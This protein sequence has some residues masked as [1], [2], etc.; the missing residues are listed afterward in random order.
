[1]SVAPIAE[2][3]VIWVMPD[4]ERRPGRIAIG[5]PSKMGDGEVRCEFLLDGLEPTDSVSGGSTFEALILAVRLLGNR[6]H[7][8]ASRGGSVEHAGFHYDSW[9]RDLFGSLVTEQPWPPEFTR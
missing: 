3:P 4:G 2:E 9:F 1:V 6:L 7:V 8:F 5:A